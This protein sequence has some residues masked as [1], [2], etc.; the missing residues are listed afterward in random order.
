MQSFVIWYRLKCDN[1]E[2]GLYVHIFILFYFNFKISINIFCYYL[3]IINYIYTIYNI[4]SYSS[5]L[6]IELLY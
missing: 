3:G 6:S 2:N 4:D 5:M 1:Q